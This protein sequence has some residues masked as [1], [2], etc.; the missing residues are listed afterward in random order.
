MQTIQAKVAVAHVLDDGQ[1]EKAKMHAVMASDPQANN[2]ALGMNAPA[3][4]VEIAVNS[5]EAKGF[6]RPGKNYRLTFT[7]IE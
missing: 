5:P 6:F 7:P 1:T 3:L 2:F 4:T